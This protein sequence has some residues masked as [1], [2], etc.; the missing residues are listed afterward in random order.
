[1]KAQNVALASSRI[2][3]FRSWGAKHYTMKSCANAVGPLPQPK[4]ANVPFINLV[5]RPQLPGQSKYAFKTLISPHKRDAFV[6]AVAVGPSASDGA[7]QERAKA[8][9]GFEKR[10]N[11][12]SGPKIEPAPGVANGADPDKQVKTCNISRYSKPFGRL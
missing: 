10:S 8:H 3:V 2:N 9:A 6:R 4:A 5:P 1:M 12:I 11:G 7:R